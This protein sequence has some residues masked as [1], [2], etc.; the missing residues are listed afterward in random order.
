MFNGVKSVQVDGLWIK[1]KDTI[2]SKNLGIF[3]QRTK[4]K[5]DHALLI[6]KWS[7]P[8]T[9]YILYVEKDRKVD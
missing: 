1:R 7:K 6:Q 2:S 5:E 4:P 8:D 9:W 3:Y